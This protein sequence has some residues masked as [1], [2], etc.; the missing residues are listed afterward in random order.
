MTTSQPPVRTLRTFDDQET[1]QQLMA[2]RLRQSPWVLVSFGVHAIALLL[3]WALLPADPEKPQVAQVTMQ[4][5]TQREVERPEPPEKP[6]VKKE[7]IDPEV[8]PIE[9]VTVNE[10]PTESDVPSEFDSADASAESAFPSSD[11]WNVAVGLNGGAAGGPYNRR[12]TGGG[13]GTGGPQTPPCVLRGLEWLAAHQDDDGRWDA[14]GF[15]KHDDQAL[16]VCDGPGNAVHDVGCTALALL[17]FL[18]ENN[19]TRSG[20][21]RTVVRRGVNWLRKQQQESGLIGG[22]MSHDYVY[23]HAI[24]AY[25]LCEACGLS[26]SRLLQKPAQRAL[27]YLESHRNPYGVWGYQPQDLTNDISVTG[28]AIMAYK[29]GKYFGMQ[30]SD[31]ALKNCDVFL[32]GVCDST[33]R[34]GYRKAGEGSSRKPGR[35]GVEFPSE[36]THAL[37][38][39][40]LFCRFFLGQDPREQSV[41]KASAKLLNTLPPVWDEQAGSIDH[42]YWY[43]ATYALFQMGG[44]EWRRWQRAVEKV[45]PEH[46]HQQESQK[47]LYGSWDP[48]G[49]WGEDGGRVYSTAILT[50]TMQAN[51][52][53]TPLVR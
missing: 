10:N 40:G 37:T 23:D 20:P 38:A 5:T 18:G 19:T 49:A 14:D 26:D 12:G 11:Q 13:G 46:Q 28:W 39:V 42:Y 51:Y 8:T 21:Y 24:A 3:V 6:E 30:V 31:A 9:D 4:D 32:D 35:H 43:Y 52:R 15:M 50:L 2:E 53:Y 25:A 22:R 1:F 41:M 45:V 33:G 27:D 47:N 17:A 29:S 44:S 7:E 48:V 36:K 34:H 16:E